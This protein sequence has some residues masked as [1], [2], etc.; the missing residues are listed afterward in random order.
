[1]VATLSP[2]W[3]GTAFAKT[4]DLLRGQAF[5]LARGIMAHFNALKKMDQKEKTH[6]TRLENQAR[7]TS[8][9]HAKCQQEMAAI[10]AGRGKKTET[11]AP[12]KHGQSV[13]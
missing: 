10:G 9:Q 2:K 12:H 3:F 7:H 5:V 13:A 4:F 6:R 11:P 1:M 8:A